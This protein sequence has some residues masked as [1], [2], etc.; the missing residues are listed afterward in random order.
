M[1]IFDAIE[2]INNLAYQVES[3]ADIKLN[4]DTN[5][6]NKRKSNNEDYIIKTRSNSK[7][8]P[9]LALNPNK[10]NIESNESKENNSNKRSRPS[11]DLSDKEN[12][13]IILDSNE[14]ENDSVIVEESDDKAFIKTVDC[15]I[16]TEDLQQFTVI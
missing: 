11:D 16:N 12:S 3:G 14:S 4:I 5:L 1:D 13:I 15:K 8:S 10:F 9:V 6:I 2:Y 7:K